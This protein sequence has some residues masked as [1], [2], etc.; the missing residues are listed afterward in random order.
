MPTEDEWQLYHQE[1]G[2]L[3]KPICLLEEFPDVWAENGA[4][5][6]ARYRAPV[7]VELK[8][9]ALPVRQRQYPI[10]RE[11]HLGIQTHLQRLKDAGILI[12]C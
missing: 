10:P 6:L 4:P 1:K 7:M 5:G 9:V 11:T 3:V 8:P 12:D 2:G